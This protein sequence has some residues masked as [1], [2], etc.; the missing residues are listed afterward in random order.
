MCFNYAE[1]TSLGVIKEIL[2][3]SFLHNTVLV[4]KETKKCQKKKQHGTIVVHPD[5]ASI[6]EGSFS[7]L[8]RHG[9]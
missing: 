5:P 4:S 1:V 7:S 8:A 9:P 6:R 3:A 2:T